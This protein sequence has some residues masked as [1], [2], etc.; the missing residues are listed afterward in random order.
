M[1]ETG[2]K[3]EARSP[4][5]RVTYAIFLVSA[6]V[7]LPVITLLVT[8]DAFLRY[9][10]NAPISWAQDLA[11]LLLFVLFCAGLT[12]S[13]AVNAHVRMDLVYDQLPSG[14][15]R[16]VDILSGAFALLFSGFLAYQAIPSTMTAWRNNSMMPTGEI[17]IWPFAAVGSLCLLIFGLAVILRIVFGGGEHRS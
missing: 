11:G 1:A 13:M 4:F 5:D 7:L 8:A 12:H 2:A 9:V 14:I 10:F 15:R 17:V 16:I 3:P 6:V